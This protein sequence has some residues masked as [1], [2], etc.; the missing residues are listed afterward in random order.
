MKKLK[1][2]LKAI[3]RAVTKKNII[4]VDYGITNYDV[5]VIVET[6]NDISTDI[7]RMESVIK[8]LNSENT[9]D[10]SDAQKESDGLHVVQESNVKRIPV[11]KKVAS[12]TVHSEK[13]IKDER[14]Y[15]Y[16]DMDCSCERKYGGAKQGCISTINPK[17][18]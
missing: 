14:I 7:L 18:L 3:Y 15:C 4:L 10:V 11:E 17:D 16:D 9:K 5:H 1:T 8:F 12:V 13:I 2:R 6:R